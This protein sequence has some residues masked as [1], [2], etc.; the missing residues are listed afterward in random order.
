[1]LA[2][3]IIGDVLEIRVGEEF[4]QIVHRRVFAPAVLEGD[5]LVVEI[6]GGLARKTREIDV[7]ASSAL[8]AMAGRARLNPRR[9]RVGRL[10]RRLSDARKSLKRKTQSQSDHH[11]P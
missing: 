6:A 7:G 3:E 1:M 2:R 9:H 10:T 11:N 4:E 5:K 8:I